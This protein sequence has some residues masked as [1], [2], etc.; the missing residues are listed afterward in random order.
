DRRLREPE[1]DL[2]DAGGAELERRR[3][4]DVER[5][6]LGCVGEAWILGGELRQQLDDVLLVVEVGVVAGQ[7]VVRPVAGV[8]ARERRRRRALEARGEVGRG[9]VPGI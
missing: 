5:E 4:L 3:L 7:R 1:A 8:E 9:G 6:T 2:P